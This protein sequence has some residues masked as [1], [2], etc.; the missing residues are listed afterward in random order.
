M[1]AEDKKNI[2]EAKKYIDNSLL[3]VPDYIKITMTDDDKKH[4]KN[5]WNFVE[6]YNKPALFPTVGES[7]G[8]LTK[9]SNYQDEKIKNLEK[10]YERIDKLEDKVANNDST[11]T[12]YASQ[13]INSIGNGFGLFSNSKTQAGGKKSKKSRTNKRKTQKK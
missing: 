3:K 1:N 5:L 10:L 4:I 7:L 11:I 6:K 8:Y 9:W 2:E 13:G 12:G